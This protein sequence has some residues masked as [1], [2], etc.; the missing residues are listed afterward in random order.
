[1]LQF[2][3]DRL[4][5]A[6]RPKPVFEEEDGALRLVLPATDRPPERGREERAMEGRKT[7]TFHGSALWAFAA[8]RLQRNRPDWSRSLSRY[9][10]APAI[11]SEPPLEYLPFAP[12]GDH[13]R[14]RVE[15]M[16]KR[17]AL[18]LER[19]RDDVRRA[20]A[21]FTVFYV[22]ARFEAND[23]AWTFVKRRY[24]P[25]RQWTRDA[26]RTRLQALLVS[27]DIPMIDALASFQAAEKGGLPAYLSVDGHWNARGNEIAFESLHPLMRRAFSCG[28]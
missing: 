4:G 21:G 25:E 8:S 22:P 2:N 27:L 3:I 11:S 12:E 9:G 5:T 20:G 6:N 18:I 13:E 10:L 14:H 24:G 19:F 28:S 16:W 1:M 15:E 26:V 7:P 17:T 23:N